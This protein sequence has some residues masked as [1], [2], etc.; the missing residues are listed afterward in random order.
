MVEIIKSHIVVPSEETPKTSLWV[1]NLDL[2][3]RRG[4]TPLVF[5]Y[6]S[7][8]NSNFFSVETLI[9][10]LAKTLV[11]FYPLAGR[12][13]VD[14]YGRIEINCNGEGALLVVARSD[15]MLDDFNDFAPST[16]MRNMFVPPAGSPD[17]PCILLML[18]VTYFKCGGVAIGTAMHHTVTDGRGA[19]HFIETWSSITRGEPNYSPPPFLDRTLL[20]ARP[21]PTIL[22]N[23]PEYKSNSKTLAH[24]GSSTSYISSI[25]R[26]SKKHINALKLQCSGTLGDRVS[27]FRAIVA[28]VWQCVC[29]ARKLDSGIETRLYTMIDM[30]SRMNPPLP[31]TY[32]GNAVIRTSVS[33]SVDDVILNPISCVAKTIRGATNQ[34]NE[35]TKSLIDYLETTNLS[36]LPRSGLPYSDLRVISWLG[37]PIYETDFGWGKPT[38]VGPALMYYSGFVYLMNSPEKDGGVSIIVALEPETTP[39]FK[40]MFL[41]KLDGLQG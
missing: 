31:V 19:F 13:G 36:N 23:H 22:F 33:A 29:V 16:E 7:N 32:F 10:S 30:R 37:M 25:I 26:I 20:L 6:R 1:S 41:E 4:Y 3:A 24:S 35:Y 18:Q 34:G 5:F 21:D 40:K 14:S 11:S 15:S 28:L 39:R 17:P 27:A 12:L 8:S 38:F 9:S 2:A